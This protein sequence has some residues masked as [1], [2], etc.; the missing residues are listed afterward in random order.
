VAGQVLDALN[1]PL[2]VLLLLVGTGG[3]VIVGELQTMALEIRW[4]AGDGRA[5]GNATSVGSPGLGRRYRLTLLGASL[6]LLVSAFGTTSASFTQQL[7]TGGMHV[8]VAFPTISP[9]TTPTTPPTDMPTATPTSK[10]TAA[11]TSK[12]TAPIPAPAG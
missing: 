10:A 1:Q 4:R 7:L 9:A 2:V 11:P 12:T 5:T 8:N 3:F 6:L